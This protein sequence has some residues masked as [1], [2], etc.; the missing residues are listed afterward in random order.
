VDT[1]ASTSPDIDPGLM[2]RA[3]NGDEGAF[4]A[5]MRLHYEPIFRLVVSIVRNEHDARDI[6]Q[7][8]WLKVWQKLPD[9]RGESRFSTWLHP[10]AVRRALDHLRKRR[11]WYDRFLPFGSTEEE[12]T[13]PE[14]ATEDVTRADADQADRLQRFNLALATL[15]PVH[16]TVLALR[17][18]QGLS[19]EEI[20][21][22][23]GIPI[24]T[25][26]SRLHHARR[27]LAKKLK[28]SP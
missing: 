13:V 17:E 4:G 26:M 2:Q 20:A 28:D 7:D 10:I 24:G 1:P 15:S 21:H 3:R 25:V 16:R 5:I 19:Y 22:S 6:C 9:F 14:P 27:T 18:I 23:T 12:N 11:R 8:V